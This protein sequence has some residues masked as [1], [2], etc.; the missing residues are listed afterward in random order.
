MRR[1]LAL[2]LLLL[3]FLTACGSDSEEGSGV[4]T[5]QL[6]ASQAIQFYRDQVAAL[7][8]SLGGA[9]NCSDFLATLQNLA[10]S[11]PCPEGGNQITEFNQTDCSEALQLEAAASW[12]WT[13]QACQIP[14]AT[15]S[16][17]IEGQL[18]WDGQ[19]L[20]T[21]LSAQGLIFNGLPQSFSHLFIE[22]FPPSPLE[23]EGQILIAA[24]FCPVTP[25]CQFC[26]I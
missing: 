19:N 9:Q 1:K 4:T 5:N 12:I 25:D 2:G 8:L 24:E 15:I 13:F 22:A 21:A 7:L 3:C 18:F 23:C 11:L 6:A 14:G 20:E 17:T 10:A 16:G 26:P